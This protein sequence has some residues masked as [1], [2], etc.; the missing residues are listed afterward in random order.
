MTLT[1]AATLSDLML[2][3]SADI[4]TIRHHETSDIMR[5][6]DCL[7][8]MHSTAAESA[9]VLLLVSL[10]A[11]PALRVWRIMFKQHGQ[12]DFRQML[13]QVNSRQTVLW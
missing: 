4:M 6:H 7:H 9:A 1:L 3:P 12:H 11:S 2:T 5:H 10:S 8:E 13:L